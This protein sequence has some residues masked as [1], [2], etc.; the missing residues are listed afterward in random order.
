MERR[1]LPIQP[2]DPPPSAQAA[3]A[4]WNLMGG[5]VW[6]ALPMVCAILGIEDPELLIRQLVVIRDRQNDEARG[7]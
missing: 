6:E 2:E 5:L 7:G 3:I 4:A 1:G